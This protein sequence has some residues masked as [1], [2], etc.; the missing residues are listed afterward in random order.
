MLPSYRIDTEIWSM[1]SFQFLILIS[2]ER[3][4]DKLSKRSLQ[5]CFTYALTVRIRLTATKKNKCQDKV[6]A[7]KKVKAADVWTIIGVLIFLTAE[8]RSCRK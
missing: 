8:T 4:T 3:Q 6:A 1:I 7:K 2:G 5:H